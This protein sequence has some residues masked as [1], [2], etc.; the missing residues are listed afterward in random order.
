MPS[1][2]STGME[3]AQ[4]VVYL[5]RAAGND[6]WFALNTDATRTWAATHPA[7]HLGDAPR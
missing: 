4:S 2:A 1:A 5:D 6:L 7:N 3:G